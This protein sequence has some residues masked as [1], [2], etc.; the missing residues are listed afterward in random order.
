MI[1]G[2]MVADSPRE[3]LKSL[4]EEHAQA[5][6][7]YARAMTPRRDLAEDLAADAFLAL[8]RRLREK[9]IPPDPLGYLL[10]SV[11]SRA[12]DEFRRRKPAP[13]AERSFP[14]PM[15]SSAE[16]QERRER[17]LTAV[18]SLESPLAEAI[19]LRIFAGL[20]FEQSARIAEIPRG[21]MESRYALA[22]E[23]LAFL[24]REERV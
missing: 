22:L 3:I 21:T 15:E 10:A 8:T 9:G 24:L 5:V 18:A 19:A 23:K 17:I 20:T 13:L 1:G 4:Y 14:A 6:W 2:S 7:A 11:R 12:I 16:S